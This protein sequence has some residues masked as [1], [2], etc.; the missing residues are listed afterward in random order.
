MS[1]TSTRIPNP[2]PADHPQNE[3]WVDEQIW[4]HRLWDSQSPW[5]LFL[6]FLSVAEAKLREGSLLD[7]QDKLYPL[8]FLPNKHMGLRNLLFNNESMPRIAARLS[9]NNAAWSAWLKDIH[10]NAEAVASPD[11]SYLR[12]RFRDFHQLELVI[13]LLRA[14]AI[15]SD[16]NRRWTSRFVFPFGPA[17]IYEDLSVKASGQ[18]S[19]EYINFTRSGE[20]LY[21][22]L[23]R[24]KSALRLKPHL[25]RFLAKDH[26][27]NQLIAILE[28]NQGSDRTRREGSYLPW[29]SHD[30]F[31]RLGEDWLAV[32]DLRLPGFDAYPYLVVL[33][34][35]HLS[36]YHLVVAA[37]QC[38]C[39]RPRFICEI[40]APRKT[41]VRELS[42]R[43]FLENIQLPRRA[44]ET[45]VENI[46]Q[47]SE[48]TKAIAEPGAF[49]VCKDI[50]LERVRWP[51]KPEDYDGPELPESLMSDFRAAA[52]RRHRQH[53]ANIHR[54]FGGGAGLVS[55]RGTN[56]LRYAPNDALLK[57][58]VL[59]NVGEH[60]EFSQFLSRLFDRYGLVFGERE[61]ER[62]LARHDLD[63]RVFQANAERLERRL[64]TLGMLRRLSD[65]CGYVINP[66]WS[67]GAHE[68]S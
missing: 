48:W 9:E 62:V 7:E 42:S 23:C 44:V 59:A 50:L 68:R 57:A 6:E 55:R 67:I 46:E 63:K 47:S 60:M 26:P 35:L 4:G 1:D 51:Q 39:N 12:Q 58:L 37:D 32:C 29:R 49:T 3:M 8:Q 10:D 13:S 30:T 16:T 45:L 54:S 66:L 24:S 41:L 28:P 31:D 5:L 25:E 15:E 27:W 22:M 34:A 14:S 56:R 11:F 19:R 64:A 20:L 38:G 36:L 21:M 52:L 17:G 33:G 53:S 65:S 40:V 43:N 18:P 61:A 2:R